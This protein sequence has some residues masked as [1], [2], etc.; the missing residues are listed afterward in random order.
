MSE[1]SFDAD[2]AIVGYGPTGVSAAN[3]LGALGVRTIA[4]EREKDIYQ[5]ARAVTVN[6]WTLRCFQSVGL[7]TLLVKDMD[8]HT[9]YRWKTFAGKELMRMT[10]PPSALGQPAAMAIY[11]PVM[12]Q[13]LRDGAARYADHVSVRYG[14]TVTA[15]SQD[16]ESA[17][18]TSDRGS[19][20]VRYVLACD[21]GSSPVRER[22]GIR[23]LGDTNETLWVVI[24]AKVKR[25]WPDRQILTFWSD[26]RRPVVD[27]ALG[28]GNHRWEFPLAAHESEAD[29][30]TTDQLWTLLNSMGVTSDDVEIHQHAFYKHHVRRAERWRDRRIFLLGDAAHLMPPWAGQGMQSGVR[31]A[32]NLAWKL[33]QV[34]SG[35]VDSA[36]A[37]SL[38]DSYEVERAPNVARMTA[39]SERL[40]R[41]IKMQLSGREKAGLMIGAV[42]AKLTG[43]TPPQPLAQG[44]AIAKGWQNGR[45][46]KGSAIGRMPPQPF[47][48]TATGRRA[49]LDDHL[50]SGFVLLGDG[51]DPSTLLSA[52]QRAAWDRLGARYVA[53]RP[54][55][56][57]SEAATDLIDL[58][59]VVLDWMRRHAAT[60][61][62]LRPDRFVCADQGDL[63]VPTGDGTSYN[64]DGD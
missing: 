6:D 18:V 21:G 59:G 48:S 45:S 31:D 43:R 19:V 54:V 34:L 57:G 50:G 33:G 17:T 37:E 22:L 52:D 7:D 32:N 53:V 28:I 38:L 58:E 46:A 41:L 61:I 9:L 2:V 11:Q 16:A 29:F 23:L 42:V 15:V 4:F 49:R 13:T 40:G 20:R 60:V 35:T 5:R 14:E 1:D 39:E 25:W 27:I 30:R 24:D 8:P 12:E 62:A 44:P 10:V 55:D 26:P 47:M 64:Q 51:R 36:A 3:F 56:G 63:S